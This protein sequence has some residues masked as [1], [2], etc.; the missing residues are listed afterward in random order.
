MPA[1]NP[2]AI[3]T[4]LGRTTNPSWPATPSLTA[5][6]SD[7]TGYRCEAKVIDSQT[8]MVG[9]AL[10]FVADFMAGDE[11]VANFGGVRSN[12]DPEGPAQATADLATSVA[13]VARGLTS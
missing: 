10:S 1:G 11:M 4:I 6:E 2:V 12:V 3:A 9:L 13:V 8:L 7:D 5:L